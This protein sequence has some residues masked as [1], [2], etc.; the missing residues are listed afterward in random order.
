MDPTLEACERAVCGSFLVDAVN[1][2]VAKKA[3]KRE[4]IQNAIDGALQKPDRVPLS[5]AT[6]LKAQDKD[7]MAVEGRLRDVKNHL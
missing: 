7:I 4:G 6:E 1:A 2:P 3:L 5:T